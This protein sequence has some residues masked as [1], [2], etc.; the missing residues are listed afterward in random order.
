MRI[1]GLSDFQKGL[2]SRSTGVLTFR[3]GFPKGSLAILCFRKAGD[4]LRSEFQ[5][6]PEG[7]LL[8]EPGESFFV[9][10]DRDAGAEAEVGG[11]EFGD[12]E[13]E[14][15]VEVIVLAAEAEDD[16]QV[17]HVGFASFVIAGDEGIDGDGDATSVAEAAD[18]VAQVGGEAVVLDG[19]KRGL[20]GVGVRRAGV[21]ELAIDECGNGFGLE[22]EAVRHAWVYDDIALELLDNLKKG[23]PRHGG[24][25]LRAH[26]GTVFLDDILCHS[27]AAEDGEKGAGA[28]VDLDELRHG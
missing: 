12:H 13:P 17:L 27:L 25:C 18:A 24:E 5:D 4:R 28:V 20:F 15:V 3:R 8:A 9:G 23:L 16:A 7:L 26:F 11:G 14:V 19:A 22:P 10:V 2:P 6:G 1:P 21:A